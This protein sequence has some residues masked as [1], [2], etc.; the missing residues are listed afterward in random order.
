MTKW[1]PLQAQKL[2]QP[3]ARIASVVDGDGHLVEILPSFMSTSERSGAGV[4][5]KYLARCPA[6]QLNFDGNVERVQAPG[7]VWPHAARASGSASARAVLG[8]P[9]AQRTR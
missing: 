9:D 3:F 8:L 4:L 6:A 2:K 7:M 1:K 5:D